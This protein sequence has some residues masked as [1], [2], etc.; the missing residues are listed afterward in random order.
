M[1]NLQL[2]SV[3]PRIYNSRRDFFCKYNIALQL[4]MVLKKIIMQNWFVLY[5]AHFAIFRI[6]FDAPVPEKIEG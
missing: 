2:Q 3:L 5:F 4:R 1:L 6:G